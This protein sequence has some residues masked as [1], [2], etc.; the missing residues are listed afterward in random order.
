MADEENVEEVSLPDKRLRSLTEKASEIFE[1]TCAVHKDKLLCSFKRVE[2]LATHAYGYF[3]DTIALN[4][5]Q[6][7]LREEH[8]D[9]RALAYNFREFLNRANTTRSIQ[10]LA[11]HEEMVNTLSKTADKA[12]N[13]I[14][15]R[16]KIMM[17]ADTGSQIDSPKSDRSQNSR[18]STKSSSSKAS[19]KLS[20]MLAIKRAKAEGPVQN[21]N[22]RNKFPQLKRSKLNWLSKKISL[23]RP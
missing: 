18:R 7:R 1:S 19:S 9:F 14:I 13:H 20:E 21:W 22:L 23:K 8:D 11:H 12:L 16:T 2:E 10:E 15:S 3:E 4:D 17:G 5:L 6:Q